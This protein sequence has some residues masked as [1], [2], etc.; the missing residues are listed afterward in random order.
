MTGF[1]GL[2]ILD[3]ATAQT[4]C[5]LSSCVRASSC[6]TV[7]QLQEELAEGRLSSVVRSAL[8]FQL[9]SLQC[10]LRRAI[11]TFCCPDGE[12]KKAVNINDLPGM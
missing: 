8:S 11:E 1:L 4:T 6:P 10:P 5:A 2:K 9:R 12:D 3:T 7:S